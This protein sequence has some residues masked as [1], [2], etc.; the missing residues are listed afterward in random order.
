M[1]AS[2]DR[3]VVLYY[4]GDSSV[5]YEAII[6]CYQGGDYKGSLKFYNEDEPV[7]P[8]TIRQGVH[9]KR[10]SLCFSIRRFNDIISI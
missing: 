1:H 3:Y 5:G 7:P 4:S 8:S 6:H 2:F 10:I 9:G